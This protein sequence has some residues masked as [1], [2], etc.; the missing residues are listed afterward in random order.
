MH[1]GRGAPKTRRARGS[2]RSCNRLS[3][4]PWLSLTSTSVAPP[5]NAPRMAALASSVISSCARGYPL[6]PRM[7][8]SNVATPAT[9]SMSTEMKTRM[10]SSPTSRRHRVLHLGGQATAEVHAVDVSVGVTGEVPPHALRRPVRDDVLVTVAGQDGERDRGL[11][12]V[13]VLPRLAQH[14][15]HL[16]LDLD[17]GEQPTALGADRAPRGDRLVAADVLRQRLVAERELLR[18]DVVETGEVLQRPLLQ[19]RVELRAVRAGV[20]HRDQPEA[21]LGHHHELGVLPVGRAPV[22]DEPYAVHVAE[23]PA[24]ADEVA[25]CAAAHVRR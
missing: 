4:V 16:R 2:R 8:W 5:V 17:L 23:E 13:D 10:V 14:G 12:L 24:D 7:I 18:L 19:Q 11:L 25:E 1:E 9:P 15:E 3:I 20:G 22:A 6:P 21:A